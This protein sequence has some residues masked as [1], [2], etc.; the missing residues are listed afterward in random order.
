MEAH[1]KA[2]LQARQDLVDLNKKEQKAADDKD[3]RRYASRA[4]KE[5]AAAPLKSMPNLW[6]SAPTAAELQ[7]RADEV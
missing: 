6:K 7:K 3:M 4:E 2:T 1:Y 5:K